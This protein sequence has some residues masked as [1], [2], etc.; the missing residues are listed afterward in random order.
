MLLRKPPIRSGSHIAK[1]FRPVVASGV[2]SYVIEGAIVNVCLC[3][4]LGSARALFNLNMYSQTM[5][6]PH[7]FL[8]EPYCVT[9]HSRRIERIVTKICVLSQNKA[10][11]L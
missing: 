6:K 5:Q 10:I 4:E 2:N 11:T 1:C 9:M 7:Y 8:S 3:S